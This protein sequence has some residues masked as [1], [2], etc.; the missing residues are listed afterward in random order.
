[1]C[2]EEGK[3][4]LGVLKARRFAGGRREREGDGYWRSC[5]IEMR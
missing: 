3:G 2:W 5:K 1:M 4:G